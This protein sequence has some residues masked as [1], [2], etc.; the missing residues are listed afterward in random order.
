MAPGAPMKK[1]IA[2]TAM[3]LATAFIVAAEQEAGACIVETS[4]VPG[5][6][7]PCI[8]SEN[9]ACAGKCI[10]NAGDGAG[11]VQTCF[12]ECVLKNGCGGCPVPWTRPLP[13]TL[14]QTLSLKVT[15]PKPSQ[16][17]HGREMLRI[18]FD[19]EPHGTD[20]PVIEVYLYVPEGKDTSDSSQH[21]LLT[22]PQKPSDPGA[23]MD[24]RGV[25]RQIGADDGDE[26]IEVL[27]VPKAWGERVTITSVKIE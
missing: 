4:D 24:I 16:R 9:C 8:C 21:Y 14:D 1:I 15:R 22:F 7:N 12:V 13:A 17:F 5:A 6:A 20:T 2:I 23:I 25:L 3:M 11:D 27:F 10:L 18:I 19:V 26:T